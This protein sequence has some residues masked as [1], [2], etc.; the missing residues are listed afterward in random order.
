MKVKANVGNISLAKAEL[1]RILKH[2]GIY[3]VILTALALNIFAI[4]EQALNSKH[5]DPILAFY[6][7]GTLKLPI[8]VWAAQYAASHYESGSIT[9]L[10]FL[11][12]SKANALG[13]RTVVTL[14]STIVLAIATIVTS[15]MLEALF[16]VVW[17]CSLEATKFSSSAAT[18][19]A[20]SLAW[21]PLIG[22][23]FGLITRSRTIASTALLVIFLVPQVVLTFSAPAV[24]RFMPLAVDARFLAGPSTMSSGSLSYF[25]AIAYLSTVLFVLAFVAW[26]R[27]NS[28]K[29]QKL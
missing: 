16:G 23:S 19:L 8:A 12:K 10:T 28:R 27:S 15:M 13:V 24:A 9:R 7:M 26:L 14:V 1:F 18:T 29:T 21:Y 11:A 4:G 25:Q 17:H 3:V 5:V 2:P 22:F 6:S 20:V